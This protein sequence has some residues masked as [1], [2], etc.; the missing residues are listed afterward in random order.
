M[1]KNLNPNA[2][3]LA[4]RSKEFLDKHDIELQTKKT[5]ERVDF[6]SKEVKLN[7]NSS[8]FLTHS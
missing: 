5:V 3:Q 6:T 1:S 7:D 8:K 2:H 4:L